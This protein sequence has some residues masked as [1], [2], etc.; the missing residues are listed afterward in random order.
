MKCRQVGSAATRTMRPAC[1]K[2]AAE[3]EE[4]NSSGQEQLDHGE[5][6]TPFAVLEIEVVPVSGSQPEEAA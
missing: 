5:L 1:T 2:R 6:P 3:A 4:G